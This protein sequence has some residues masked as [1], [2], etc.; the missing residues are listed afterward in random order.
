MAKYFKSYKRVAKVLDCCAVPENVSKKRPRG[1]AGKILLGLMRKEEGERKRKR[2]FR[3][4]GVSEPKKVITITLDNPDNPY[5]YE[6]KA[7]AARSAVISSA[8]RT[9]GAF[10]GVHILRPIN[11][12]AAGAFKKGE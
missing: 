5:Y 4:L 7:A 2:Y 6:G 12:I 1:L 10:G 9:R 11:N 8:P 3:R